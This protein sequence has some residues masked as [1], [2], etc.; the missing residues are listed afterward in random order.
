VALST[1]STRSLTP[2]A[3]LS[4]AQFCIN[5]LERN[6]FDFFRFRMA[7]PLEIMSPGK[8]WVPQALQL[9]FESKAVFHAIAAVG[10]ANLS[11]G[12]MSHPTMTGQHKPGMYTDALEQY[13]KTIASLNHQI[14]AVIEERGP[15]QPVLLTC[16]LLVCFELHTDRP[17]MAL[18]HHIMGRNIMQKSLG[19]IGSP[20][21][22]QSS[23][24]LQVLSKAFDGL[25]ISSTYPS[26]VRTLHAM[27][28][29]EVHQSSLMSLALTDRLAEAWNKLDQLIDSSNQLLRKLYLLAKRQVKV[30]YRDTLDQ[31]TQY[32]LASCWSKS[33]ALP[34]HDT[35]LVEINYLLEQLDQWQHNTH[36]FDGCDQET[37]RALALLQVRQW[38]ASF[39]LK[40]CREDRETSLDCHEGDFIRAM[41]LAQLYLKPMSTMPRPFRLRS[42]YG[43]GQDDDFNLEQGILPALY[44]ISL[45]SRTS[46]IRHRAT[47][48]LANAHRREGLGSSTVTAQIAVA[49]IRVEENRARGMG[50]HSDLLSSD[51]PETARFADIVHAA[52]V[53]VQRPTCRLVC[54][55]YLHESDGG[56]EIIEYL[57]KGPCF[58]YSNC[59]GRCLTGFN[60]E[61]SKEKVH[62]DLRGF[63]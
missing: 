8:G 36:V 60:F 48:I 16:L 31:A 32:C 38:T 61:V 47:D 44:L 23:S 18:R 22:S 2:T 10:S 34:A 3:P 14:R 11:I 50:S 26:N 17:S 24:S 54:A 51:V 58:P 27:T 46:A 7:G 52:G 45:K 35:T 13:S 56:I 63:L 33:M 29:G 39:A 49:I 4:I 41:D 62:Y 37:T 59:A 19:S 12:S 28:E 57:S 55:R 40:T 53:D 43:N 9:S 15:L 6:A 5:N 21:S 20:G 42:I 25:G 30:A 1:T